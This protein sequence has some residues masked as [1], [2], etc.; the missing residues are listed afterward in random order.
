VAS[1]PAGQPAAT[2]A[3]LRQRFVAFALV[4][5]GAYPRVVEDEPLDA[6]GVRRREHGA[7][8]S[9]LRPSEQRRTIAGSRVHDGAEVV[10]PRLDR[11]A[12]R[13]VG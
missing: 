12:S 2:V 7:G 10:H 6:V 5:H 1:T 11:E 3:N 4:D 13:A 8:R 9:R